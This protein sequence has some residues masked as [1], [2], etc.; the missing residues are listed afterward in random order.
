MVKRKN[1]KYSNIWNK[2]TRKLL[3][4]RYSSKHERG[5]KTIPNCTKWVNNITWTNYWRQSAK[6][7]TN[8][9]IWDITAT[10]SFSEGDLLTFDM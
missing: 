2:S 7:D 8:K 4:F 9:E 5:Q 1:C 6:G 10:A 3:I